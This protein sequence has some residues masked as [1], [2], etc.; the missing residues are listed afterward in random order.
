M[1]RITCGKFVLLWISV[2]VF[3]I[4][5]GIRAYSQTVIIVEKK[6]VSPIIDGEIDDIWNSVKDVMVLDIAKEVA[7][8]ID[9][10]LKALYTDSH[11]F[12]LVRF[13][14][15][16]ES[17]LH[18]PWI[19]DPAVEKYYTGVLREDTFIFK[20]SMHGFKG[21][22]SLKKGQPHIADIWF[23][24]AN[25]TDPAGFADD[26][27]HRLSNTTCSNCQPLVSESGQ[28]FYLDRTGDKGHPAYKTVLPLGKEGDI[29]SQY[30][31]RVPSGSRADVRAKGHWKDNFWTIEYSRLLDTG[32]KDDLVFATDGTY[33]FGISRFEISGRK[34]IPGL[35][36]PYGQ[37]DVHEP[38]I[39]KFQH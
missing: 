6:T 28:T 24:K 18:K 1:K 39:L 36:Q 21:D 15:I 4:F 22:L 29:V 25:R 17:R 27:I 35:N 3:F 11:I 32:H 34:F 10:T 33:L 19:W 12:F 37:G 13:P 14:D 2:G 31:S 8:N 38:L 20:W 16:D 26:K 30:C 23:W 5:P 7:P 9:V